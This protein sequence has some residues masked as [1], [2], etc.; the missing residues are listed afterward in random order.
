MGYMLGIGDRTP[1]TILFM[2]SGGLIHIDCGSYFDEARS[3]KKWPEIVPFRL[4]RMMV[5]VLGISGVDG[6]YTIT[7]NLVMSVVRRNQTALSAFLDLFQGVG[8]EAVGKV[9][10]K[11]NGREFGPELSSELHVKRLIEDATNEENLMSMPADWWPH[12]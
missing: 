6:I 9:S 11:L 2:K 5:K 3:G 1:F 12:W 4:T 8:V 7:A 10:E